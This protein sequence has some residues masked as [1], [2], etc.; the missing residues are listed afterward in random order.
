MTDL[1]SRN[2][3]CVLNFLY[4]VSFLFPAYLI[5]QYGH[6]LF[7]IQRRCVYRSMTKGRWKGGGGKHREGDS[8]AWFA[9]FIE[10]SGT[11]INFSTINSANSRVLL[12]VFTSYCLFN[13][14]LQA[15]ELTHTHT[16]LASEH[17]VCER[18]RERDFS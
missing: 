12:Q 2:P 16:H 17:T 11:G 9:I 10:D 18:K 15:G 14:A 7:Q 6:F 8:F 1:K 3:R 4:A 13:A 5:G